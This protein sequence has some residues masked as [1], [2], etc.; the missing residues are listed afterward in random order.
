[1]PGAAESFWVFQRRGASPPFFVSTGSRAPLRCAS[2]RGYT[3]FGIGGVQA[4][5]FFCFAGFPRSASRRGY[6]KCGTSGVAGGRF[7][8]GSAFLLNKRLSQSRLSAKLGKLR[9][10]LLVR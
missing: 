6:T 10:T 8:G 2:R 5:S 3:K 7:A 4:L 1:M 9:A